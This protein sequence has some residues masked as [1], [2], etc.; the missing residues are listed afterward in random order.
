LS[1]FQA[2][3]VSELL[4]ENKELQER[5]SCITT[6]HEEKMSELLETLRAVRGSIIA[7]SS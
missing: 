1:P 7:S 5:I 6:E 4:Q 2:S 3:R